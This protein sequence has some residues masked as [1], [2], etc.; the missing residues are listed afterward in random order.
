MRIFIEAIMDPNFSKSH[1]MNAL[2]PDNKNVTTCF[3][4]KQ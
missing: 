1:Q 3:D 4:N 2:F